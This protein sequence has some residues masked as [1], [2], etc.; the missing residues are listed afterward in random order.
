MHITCLAVDSE[1][2]ESPVGQ[3]RTVNNNITTRTF[4]G[5][6]AVIPVISLRKKSTEINI[7]LQ[8]LEVGL[9]A[10]SA[11]DFLVEIVLNGTLTG[12]SWTANTG[13]GEFDVSATAITG[14]VTIYSTY[15]RGNTNAPSVLSTEI[16]KYTRDLNLGATL[17]GVSEIIS[18]VATNITSNAQANAFINYRDLK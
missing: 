4:S 10:N 7:P 12:A 2:Q 9:F 17:A 1:G 18:V 14:G 16:T 15:I 3:L 8:V 6:G 13:V 5:T 11:D